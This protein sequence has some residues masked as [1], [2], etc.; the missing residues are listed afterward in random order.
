MPELCEVIFLSMYLF[1]KLKKKKLKNIEVLKG[2]YTHQKMNGLDEIK[3]VLPLR[4]IRINSKG[5]FLWFE[6]K[7]KNNNNWYLLNTLGL[8]GYWDTDM[9]NIS[10]RV[11][12]EFE[13]DK[14]NER[15]Y[16]VDARN[17]G[18]LEFTSDINK[19]N[20]KLEKLAPDFLK[21]NLNYDIMRERISELLSKKRK[22]REIVKILMSQDKGEGL[23]S[24]LGNYLTAEIL[25]KAKISP[26]RKLSSL[27]DDE[28]KN[29]TD[30]IKYITKQ[31]YTNNKTG[32][33]ELFDENTLKKHYKKVKEEIYPNYH[34]DIKIKED[35]DFNVY[36]LEKD[37]YGNTIKADK[38]IP[39]RTTYWVPKIQK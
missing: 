15:Y 38:I 14:T 35:F 25:Y 16:Y 24:G 1:K 13:S 2:R 32:Y 21:E 5:K 11:M 22:E 19:L 39:G 3:E 8:T 4:V 18:T 12:F 33:M 17:F 6:L 23:G 29:L 10:N 37:K 31:C 9:D 28:I 26:Y 27:S 30:S 20:N 34:S 36:G 7:D